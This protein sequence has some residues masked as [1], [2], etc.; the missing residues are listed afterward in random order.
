MLQVPGILALGAYGVMLYVATRDS[1]SAGGGVFSGFVREPITPDEKL[2]RAYDVNEA[3]SLF[4]RDPDRDILCVDPGD[5][6]RRER[7]SRMFEAV[8]FFGG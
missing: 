4:L 8:E 2:D 6:E 5:L 3:R 1:N 7:V